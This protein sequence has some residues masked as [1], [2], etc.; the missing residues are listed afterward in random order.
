MDSFAE[1]VD[2][3]PIAFGGYGE[4]KL[5][6]GVLILYLLQ[7]EWWDYIAHRR[8]VQNGEAVDPVS[9]AW[10]SQDHILREQDEAIAALS[11]LSEDGWTAANGGRLTFEMDYSPRFYALAQRMIWAETGLVRKL[12]RGEYDLELAQLALKAPLYRAATH[13]LAR[14]ASP[15]EG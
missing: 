9:E 8:K 15:S 6:H 5:D 14:P 12:R 7:P 2:L 1:Q 11:T 3:P 4:R 10:K 13:L